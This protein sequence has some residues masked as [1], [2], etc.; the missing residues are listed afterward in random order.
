M[1]RYYY[2]SCLGAAR[3]SA[4]MR[5]AMEFYRLQ[6]L[7]GASAASLLALAKLTGVRYSV[8]SHLPYIDL[9]TVAP[10]DLLHVLYLGI[11]KRHLKEMF[12]SMENLHFLAFKNR[13]EE[14]MVSRA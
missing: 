8:L 12:H 2:T 1:D 11:V 9:A 6:E 4:F 5:K 7:Q 10:I 14:L 3:D 13:C